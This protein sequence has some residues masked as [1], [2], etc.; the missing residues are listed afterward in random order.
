[1][2]SS[3]RRGAL[4]ATVLALSIVSLSACGAGN[5][6]QT[7]QVKPD[8]AAASV[9]DIKLQNVNV[10]TQPGQTATG[11]AVITGQVFNN[12]TQDQTLT[13]VKLPGKNA[14]VQ[15][16][17]AKGSGP[18]VVPAGGSVTLGGKGNASAVLP[19]GRE[20]L[21]DGAQQ[22]LSFV[23]SR[24]GDVRV[25]AFV[26]P[27][28]SYFK[29]WGP[30]EPSQSPQTSQSPQPGKPGGGKQGKPA[31]ATAPAS[32]KAEDKSKKDGKPETGD[33]NKGDKA[34][35]KRQTPAA[36]DAEH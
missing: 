5:S 3:L 18:V 23:F 9:G 12:G 31:G 13:A 1:M 30:A 8:N 28:T 35:K 25:G 21:K 27:A 29:D 4:A 33:Q 17:G 11:P 34:D 22:Q 36:P 26:V 24:T 7:L 15:L 20:S 16:T 14:T 10:V 19:N 6:A 2:S 32:G